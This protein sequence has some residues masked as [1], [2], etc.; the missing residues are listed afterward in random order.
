MRTEWERAVECTVRMPC[1]TVPSVLRDIEKDE[2][3]FLLFFFN[4]LCDTRI[5]RFK[6]EIGHV[7]ETF[8]LIFFCY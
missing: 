8:I 6:L 4:S 3:A 5:L 1:L 2:G 7:I